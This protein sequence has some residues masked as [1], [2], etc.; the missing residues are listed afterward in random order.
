MNTS[1]KVSLKFTRLPDGDFGNFGKTILAEFYDQSDFANPPVPQ[2][3]LLAGITAFENSVVAQANGGKLAT[4]EKKQC[5]KELVAM[6]K[7]L[8]YFVQLKCK[9]DLVILLSSGF[10]AQ[11]RNHTPTV[12]AKAVVERITQTHS[13]VALVTAK[14]ERGAKT[15][16]VQAAEIDENGA[17]G[18][19]GPSVLRSSSRK[20]PVAGLTAG[21]K[22]VFRVRVIG[23]KGDTSEWSDTLAQRVM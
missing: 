7:E 14:A 12:L 19:Y 8:A 10:L 1:V 22:Y 9:D 17:L 4:A 6:L 3:D 18:P 11:N 5:R 13:G 21:K 15:Y 2:A 16:E 20:I 23:G